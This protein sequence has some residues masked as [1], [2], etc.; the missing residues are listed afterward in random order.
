MEGAAIVDVLSSHGRYH[1]I[2]TLIIFVTTTLFIT[3]FRVFCLVALV[4]GGYLGSDGIAGYC[5]KWDE[6]WVF[7]ER[8]GMI[9]FDLEEKYRWHGLNSLYQVLADQETAVHK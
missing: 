8:Y 3:L 9:S 6:G 5:V 1:I 7:P 4:L 2:Y